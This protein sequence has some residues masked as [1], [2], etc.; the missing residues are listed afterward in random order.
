M[1]CEE[2]A[3]HGVHLRVL[4]RSDYPPNLATIVS[5]PHLIFVKGTIEPRDEKA[6]AIVGSR[7]CTPYGKRQAERLAHDLACAGWT[8]V[9]GLARGIDG[10]AHRGALKAKGRTLAVLAGGLS[11]I[12]PPEHLSLAEEVTA[13]GALITESCMSMEPMAGLFPARNR[14]ISGLSRAVVIVE[15]AEKS[16]ALITARMAAEQG[17][18]VFALPGAVDNP[19]SAGVL[20][21]LR[22]GSKLVRN[23]DDILEDLLGVS[24]MVEAKT[25][26]AA[27]PPPTHLEGVQQK[28]WALLAMQRNVDELTQELNLPIHELTRHLTLMEMKKAVRRLPGNC[29]ERF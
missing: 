26:E 16:G 22:D 9:S 25:P 19:S 15:A 2:I 24:S 20:K 21:L 6:I 29:Y 23:A 12:Y 8:V 3:R 5:A 14:I 13:S 17:R 7:A 4:G 11:R 10:H 28:I 1:E 27:P 18:E